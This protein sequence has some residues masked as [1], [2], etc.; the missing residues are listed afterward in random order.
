MPLNDRAGLIQ[1]VARADTLQ[2]V[3]RL[4]RRIAGTPID[5]ELRAQVE[6]APDINKGHLSSMQQLECLE[7][8]LELT[9]GK[10]LANIMWKKSAHLCSHTGRAELTVLRR[11]VGCDLAGAQDCLH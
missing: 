6:H 4:E 9:N 8:A 1:W 3:C 7:L 2:N 5:L 10:E 11:Y